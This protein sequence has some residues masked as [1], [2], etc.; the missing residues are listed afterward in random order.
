MHVHRAAEATASLP[1][2]AEPKHAP[3]S[4]Q[5]RLSFQQSAALTEGTPQ[6]AGP[7]QPDAF[8]RPPLFSGFSQLENVVGVGLGVHLSDPPHTDL[9]SKGQL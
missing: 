6:P 4:Q 8:P 5:V 1:G 9:P 2:G 7:G 3:E